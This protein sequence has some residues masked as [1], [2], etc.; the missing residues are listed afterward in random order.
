MR[1]PCSV[2]APVSSSSCAQRCAACARSVGRQQPRE[3]DRHAE[4][5]LGD[6][7]RADAARAREDDR[8]RQQLGKHQ[9]ADADRRAL[10]PAQARADAKRSRST[11]GVKATSASRQQAAQRVAIPGVEERVLRKVGAELIDEARAASP[12]PAPD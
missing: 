7:A 4:H 6:R 2:R 1:W 9:A 3:R 12:T 8:A 11:N 5:V 10:H